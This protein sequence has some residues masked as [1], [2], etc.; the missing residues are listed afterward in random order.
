MVNAQFV[1]DRQAPAPILFTRDVLGESCTVKIAGHEGSIIAPSLPA[2]N[3]DIKRLLA[4]VGY[5]RAILP[6]MHG[7]DFSVD[8]GWRYSFPGGLSLVSSFL[9]EFELIDDESR[10]RDQLDQVSM[11]F[12]N[13][14][15]LVK[16]WI[17]SYT[18]QLLSTE[19][20]VE[21]SGV[22]SRHYQRALKTGDSWTNLHSGQNTMTIIM[23]SRESAVTLDQWIASVNHANLGESPPA[24]YLLLRD[25]RQSFL[26]GEFQYSVI[27]SAMAAEIAIGSQVEKVMRQNGASQQD[28]DR[29]LRDTLGGLIRRAGGLNI[30]LPA[31]ANAD[32]VQK[33]NEAIHENAT[34]SKD[35]VRQALEIAASIVKTLVPLV[36]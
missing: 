29:A 5:D 27:S 35:E 25:A 1:Y 9:L 30:V 4:P 21:R 15:S 36:V 13:W 8:W 3:P 11:E 20:I 19:V 31:N 22:T 10:A 26:R 16:I 32:M 23:D 17:E 18:P 28:I 33:R 7:G 12:G 34:L 24:S 6:R 14:F 2:E